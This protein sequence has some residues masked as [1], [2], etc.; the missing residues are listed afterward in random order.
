MPPW[1]V[2]FKFFFGDMPFWLVFFCMFFL[3]PTRCSISTVA[4]RNTL[5]VGAHLQVQTA[6]TIGEVVRTVLYRKP[7]ALCGIRTHDLCI[8]KRTSNH[9]SYWLFWMS[10]KF[11]ILKLCVQNTRTS[12]R[13]YTEW[14]EIF[15]TRRKCMPSVHPRTSRP[16]L[17]G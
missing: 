4:T 15:L 3:C 14:D 17:H 11:C 9:L 1:E 5:L 10:W 6:R 12:Y 8:R 16:A 7:T 2:F 13:N